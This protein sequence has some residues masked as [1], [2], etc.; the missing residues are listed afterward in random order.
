MEAP[1]RLV[2]S[3]P[4]RIMSRNDLNEINFL[5]RPLET[6]N[7]DTVKA[8]CLNIDNAFDS[9]WIYGSLGDGNLFNGLAL[10]EGEPRRVPR[11]FRSCRR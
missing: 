7:I 10:I 2:E 1:S 4:W 11:L 5:L 8:S 3:V 9:K 6:M